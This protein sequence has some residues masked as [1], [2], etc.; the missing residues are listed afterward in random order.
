MAWCCI[1]ATFLSHR[2]LPVILAQTQESNEME[3]ETIKKQIKSILVGENINFPDDTDLI[4][5]IDF[6]NRKIKSNIE[7]VEKELFISSN[8]KYND[9]NSYYLN[10]NEIQTNTF[11]FTKIILQNN[12]LIKILIQINKL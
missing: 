7:I 9:L 12:L 10:Q 8:G 2:T 11:N 1:F 5:I 4:E 6:L 3:I